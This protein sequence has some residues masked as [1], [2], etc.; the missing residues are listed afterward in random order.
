MDFYINYYITYMNPIHIVHRATK[1]STLAQRYPNAAV[2]DVTSKGPQPWVKFSPFYPHGNIPIPFAYEAD[3]VKTA[4]SVEGIWQGLK[5]F[6]TADID[7]IV[8]HLKN[9]RGLKRTQKR[10]GQT[11]GHRAGLNGEKLLPYLEARRLIYL[12]SYRFVLQHHLQTELQVL[13]DLAEAQ[14]LILLDYE[15][16]ADP[17]NP[18]KPL[19]HAALIRA[20]LLGQWPDI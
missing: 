13:S 9:M 8:M 20:E 16:N 17:H 12:P 6:E 14:T 18:A 5:V 11:L 1:T 15:T 3:N 10:F 19:S 4:Q 2:I 7:E